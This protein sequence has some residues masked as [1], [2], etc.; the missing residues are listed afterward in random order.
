MA[1]I[2]S[3]YARALVDVVLGDKIDPGVATEQLKAFL[4]AVKESVQLRR[5]WESPA[6]LPEQKRAVLD[7]MALKMGAVKQVRNFMAALIDHRRLPMLEQIVRQFQIELDAQLG[8][9]EADI[10][11]ARALSG[12]ERREIES[13]VERLTSKKVRARYS[14]NRELLGGIVVRIGSTIYDGSVQGQLQKLKEQ[15]STT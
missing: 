8:F 9:A 4:D 3:R 10:T 15:L 12:E 13:R 14:A 1:A 6:V 7:A 11:S 5:V 2:A